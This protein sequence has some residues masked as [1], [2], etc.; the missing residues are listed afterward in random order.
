ME[1][2]SGRDRDERSTRSRAGVLRAEGHAQGLATAFLLFGLLTSVQYAF[3]RAGQDVDAAYRL[4][5]LA[6]ASYM[7]RLPLSLYAQIRAVPGVKAA[8]YIGTFGGYYQDPRNP[9]GGGCAASA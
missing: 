4:V 8:T 2:T 5:T 1:L 9:V 3:L 6:K 7:L